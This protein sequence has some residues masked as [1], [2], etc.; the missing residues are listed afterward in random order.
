MNSA[1]ITKIEYKPVSGSTFTEIAII[2]HSGNFLEILEETRAGKV[3]SA[4]SEFKIAKIDSE[5]DEL[6]QSIAESKNTFNLTDSN[7]NVHSVGDAG[8]RAK[9]IYSRHVDGTPGAFNGYICTITRKGP[10]ACPVSAVS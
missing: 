5:T 1:V 2:P 3:F 7:G 6:I 9:F 8:Y 10:N 4:K